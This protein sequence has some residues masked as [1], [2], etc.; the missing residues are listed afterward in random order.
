M[1][2]IIQPLYIFNDRTRPPSPPLMATDKAEAPRIISHYIPT[3][4]QTEARKF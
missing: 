4:Y 2:W 3:G 1:T